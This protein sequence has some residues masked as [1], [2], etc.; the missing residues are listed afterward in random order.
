MILGTLLSKGVPDPIVG[1]LSILSGLGLP[2]TGYQ[3]IKR[4]G[5]SLGR[6]PG[7]PIRVRALWIGQ[8]WEQ[9]SYRDRGKRQDGSEGQAEGEKKEETFDSF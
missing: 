7:H 6:E 9:D 4:P 8:V 3:V 1:R 5:I 2:G